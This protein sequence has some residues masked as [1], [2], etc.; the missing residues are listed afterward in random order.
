M[1]M[2]TAQKDETGMSANNQSFKLSTSI[3]FG[4][5]ILQWVQSRERKVG[6][7]TTQSSKRQFY[8]VV[9]PKQQ[10]YKQKLICAAFLRNDQHST[11]VVCL[12]RG[13]KMKQ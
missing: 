10:A 4:D 5:K 13:F 1:N 11:P 9:S 12:K 6:H 2:S 7:F 8:I 3:P